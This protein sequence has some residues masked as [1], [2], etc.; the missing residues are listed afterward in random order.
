MTFDKDGFVWLVTGNDSKNFASGKPGLAKYDAATGDL[1][2]LVSFAPGSC[3][4]HGLEYHDGALIS[5]DAGYHPGWPIGDSPCS[6]YVFR[7]D[8]L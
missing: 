7:I 5:V 1:L 6:G 4:P 3:D 2:E 8:L